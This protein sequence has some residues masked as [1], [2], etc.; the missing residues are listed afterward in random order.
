MSALGA[1]GQGGRELAVLLGGVLPR[2]DDLD[3]A[4]LRELVRAV[5][6]LR[7]A[8]TGLLETVGQLAGA[9]RR[10][11][12]AAGELVGTGV[13]LAEP[14]GQGG[15]TAAEGLGRVTARGRRSQ[16]GQDLLTQGVDQQRDAALDGQRRL[17]DAAVVGRGLGVLRRGAVLG[18]MRVRQP[19][20]QLVEPGPLVQQLRVR[21]GRRWC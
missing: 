1:L 9:G 3:D 17:P 18:G 21:L 19:G 16:A 15:R 10:G 2:L 11:A 8:V 14:V 7:G 12:Q 5:L 4:L 6:Q 13:Q 20:A